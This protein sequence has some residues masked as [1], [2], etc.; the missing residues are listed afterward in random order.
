M[1]DGSLI[2]ADLLAP[3][4]RSAL[5]DVTRLPNDVSEIVKVDELQLAYVTRVLELCGGN[6]FLTAQKLGISR[7]TLARWLSEPDGSS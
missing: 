6:K 7:Q 5:A 2:D 1:A 3:I 4:Q